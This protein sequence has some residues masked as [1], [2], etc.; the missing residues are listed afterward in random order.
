MKSSEIIKIMQ[1]KGKSKAKDIEKEIKLKLE[2]IKERAQLGNEFVTINIFNVILMYS[3]YLKLK[4]NQKMH[5]I[6]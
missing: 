6:Y 5:L 1:K 4:I 3:N 2:K